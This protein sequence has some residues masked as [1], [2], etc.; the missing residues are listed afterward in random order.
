MPGSRVDNLQVS[1]DESGNT[2]DA[3]DDA[4]DANA[5]A[6][7]FDVGDQDVIKLWMMWI[8]GVCNEVHADKVDCHCDLGQRP[9]RVLTTR[10]LEM[11]YWASGKREEYWY[12]ADLLLQ[13]ARWWYDEDEDENDTRDFVF[14][15]EMEE[16]DIDDRL[17][18]SG[19]VP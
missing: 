16:G 5:D 11:W 1:K 18:F 15:G 13:G 3:D 8:I 12:W 2:N 10:N 4:D 6:D 9:C 7:A 19:M 14:D 17:A